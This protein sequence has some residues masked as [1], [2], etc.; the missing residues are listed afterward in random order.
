LAQ[1][2]SEIGQRLGAV[3]AAVATPPPEPPDLTPHLQAIA[4]G[5]NKLQE[6]MSALHQATRQ[7]PNKIIRNEAGD[8]IGMTY[9]PTLDQGAQ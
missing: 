3:E 9:D 6:T 8:A 2:E 4:D 5:Q 1:R 7:R